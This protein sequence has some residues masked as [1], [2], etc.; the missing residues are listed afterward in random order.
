MKIDCIIK[1][2]S[3]VQGFNIYFINFGLGAKWTDYQGN[4]EPN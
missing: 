4:Q 3:D 1:Y 2:E